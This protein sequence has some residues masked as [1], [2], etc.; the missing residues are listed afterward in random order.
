MPSTFIFVPMAHKVIAS[1]CL[2]L[3]P[4]VSESIGLMYADHVCTS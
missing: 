3:V 2:S 1:Y 4:V